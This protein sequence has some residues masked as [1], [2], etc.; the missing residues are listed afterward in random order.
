MGPAAFL[1][2]AH[3][4]NDKRWI[5]NFASSLEKEVRDQLGDRYGA[6]KIFVDRN[7]IGWGSEW[8]SRI[9]SALI[10]ATF[11]IPVLSPSYFTS[12][13]CDKEFITFY[14][15]LNERNRKRQI[16]PLLL[17]TID[18]LPKSEAVKLALEFQ[19]SDWSAIRRSPPNSK[20]VRSEL[21]RLAKQIVEALPLT[22]QQ[23]NDGRSPELIE[24]HS[25]MGNDAPAQYFPKEIL[26]SLGKGDQLFVVGR[27][28]H[29]WFFQSNPYGTL[30]QDI[31]DAV[32]R[33]AKLTFV[34]QDLRADALATPVN[35]TIGELTRHLREVEKAFKTL[36]ARLGSEHEHGLKLLHTSVPIQRSRVLHFRLAADGTQTFVRLQYDL[37]M[38]PGLKPFVVVRDR[39]LV[40]DVIVETEA[41]IHNAMTDKQFDQ[42][43]E[44]NQRLLEEQLRGD[45][46]AARKRVRD[47]GYSNRRKNQPIRLVRQICA[48]R[49]NSP[50][51]PLCVQILV[52][53][54]CSTN[55]RMCSYFGRANDSGLLSLKEMEELLDDVR[56]MGTRAVVFSGG[57]PLARDGLS[58]ILE[59]ARSIGVRVGLLTNGVFPVDTAETT[60]NDILT[61]IVESCDW[62]QVSIDSLEPGGYQ[63]IRKLGT[64]GQ[65]REFLKTLVEK[66]FKNIDVC[67]TIQN[68][69][70]RELMDQKFFD[71]VRDNIPLGIYARLKFAHATGGPNDS[72]FLIPKSELESLHRA[73]INL[74]DYAH[75]SDERTNR[76]QIAHITRSSNANEDIAKGAPMQSLLEELSRKQAPCGVMKSIMFIDCNG[77]I[78][79]CCYTFNDN[80]ANWEGRG[81]FRIGNWRDLHALEKVKETKVNALKQLWE[82]SAFGK[83]REKAL[84]I[85]NDA[86]GRCTRHLH[87]NDFIHEVEKALDRYFEVGGDPRRLEAAMRS[88]DDPADE[89]CDPIWL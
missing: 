83:L 43:R 3:S 49:V 58:S 46:V 54:R 42:L 21:E 56:D 75:G 23:I 37:S 53:N 40:E 9:E 71:T 47:G 85:H 12:P 81:E 88:V 60:R 78:Y 13:Y 24:A 34:V 2:Y 64:L 19:H 74:D 87:Q 6:F 57:E 65:V 14:R 55:C 67:F 52:S 4:D 77:D 66:Q 22:P 36:R 68:S 7:D 89:R 51:P 44:S 27:T 28:C 15:K 62:V 41:I 31:N 84:P 79:P 76:E 61:A 20:K 16:L 59:Y 38:K 32:I 17:R 39:S 35:I 11:L 48:W 29:S 50:P 10:E 73:L 25:G 70:Y 72:Q 5:T 30:E 80:V 69:N 45:V 1:S 63:A 82:S 26:T 18:H 86:C 8:R 33:G